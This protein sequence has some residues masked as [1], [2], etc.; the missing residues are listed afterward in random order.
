MIAIWRR[1]SRSPCSGIDRPLLGRGGGQLVHQGAH[2]PH[3]LQLLELALEVGHVEALA[4]DH[5]LGQ[6]LGFLVIDLAM[7]LLDQADDV[8]HAEDPRRHA[9]RIER[10]E[11]LGLLANAHEDDG[12]A[13]DVPHRK[14]GATARIAVRLGEN[15]AGQIEGRAERTSG[16]HGVLARHGVDHEQPLSRMHGGVD[17]PH[18]RHQALID[19]QA[20]GGVDDQ[21]VEHASLGL[22]Q[23][24]ARDVRR[25]I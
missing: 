4:L 8:A 1:R 3:L 22:L 5:L 13:G 23:R 12:L 10:L 24:I 2:A 7:D 18:L 6:A 21:H 9:L 20:S 19:V 25:R 11:G 17:L 15:H 16:I 14:R